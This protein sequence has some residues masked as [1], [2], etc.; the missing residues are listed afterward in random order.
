MNIR[1][2]RGLFRAWTASALMAFAFAAS[3]QAAA[4][5]QRPVTLV[6]P[7]TPGGSSDLLAR[8]YA[9]LLE[10]ALGTSIVV[11]NRGGGSGV[12]GAQAVARAP[13]DGY[14]LLLA[15]TTGIA[16]LPLLRKDISYDVDRDFALITLLGATPQVLIVPPNGPK[17]LEAF[18]ALAKS[19]PG[20]LNYSS[21]GVATPPHLVGEL[22]KLEGGL[23]IVHVPFNGSSASFANLLGGHVDAAFQNIDSVLPHVKSGAV[24]ALAVASAERSAALPDVPTLEEKGIHGVENQTWFGIAAPAGL[25]PEVL[26]ALVQASRKVV[27]SEDFQDYLRSQAVNATPVGPQAFKTLLDDERVR[28]RRVID[29]AG[30]RLN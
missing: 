2:L 17:T 22:F 7:F 30:I 25:P 18:L 14:T 11:E 23:D 27:E 6:V 12:I 15:H 1:L 4:Y 29:A 8:K 5:P 16:V 20:K 9:S 28:W 26:E 24:R 19:Q 10:S 21:G 3:A 13:A